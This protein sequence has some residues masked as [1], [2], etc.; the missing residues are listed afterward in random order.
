LA[1]CTASIASA[2]MALARVAAETGVVMGGI[3][4]MAGRTDQK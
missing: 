4:G 3:S 1:C 2:R